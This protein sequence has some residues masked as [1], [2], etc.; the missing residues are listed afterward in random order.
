MDKN[1]SNLIHLLSVK[2]IKIIREIRLNGESFDSTNLKKHFLRDEEILNLMKNADENSDENVIENIK[3][4]LRKQIDTF[5]PYLPEYSLQKLKMKINHL[6]SKSLFDDITE[7]VAILG[8]AYNNYD[9][10]IKRVNSFFRDFLDRINNTGWRLLNLTDENIK[11]I[12]ADDAEDEKVLNSV[13]DINE[14][15]VAEENFEKLKNQIIDIT[16]KINILVE[17]KLASKSEQKISLKE[18]Y[19]DINEQL[20]NYK[21]KYEAI[22]DELDRYKTEAIIDDLTGVF[23]KKYMYTVFEELA[24]SEKKEKPYIVVMTDL[25]NFKYVNDNYGHTTGDHVLK[26]FAEIM[27]KISGS[28]GTCFRYGGEEFVLTFEDI[29]IDEACKL[30]E[31]IR[32]EMSKTKFKLKNEKISITASFGVSVH[33]PKEQPSDTLERADKNLYFSKN[34]GKNIVYVESKPYKK[35]D[36]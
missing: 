14:M 28:R 31:S 10:S 8:S 13:R 34:N 15:V 3:V 18:N 25:D 21:E 19:N 33:K 5:R 23:R 30:V 2:V 35:D 1:I 16:D 29:S 36:H 4:I 12:E 24:A 20:E 17:N 11:I 27:K 9:E 32:V 6:N 22:K 7:I 26:H